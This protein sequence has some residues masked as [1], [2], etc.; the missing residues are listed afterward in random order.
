MQF[1]FFEHDFPY[2][3]YSYIIKNMK[4]ILDIN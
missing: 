3:M 2:V 4:K 1:L